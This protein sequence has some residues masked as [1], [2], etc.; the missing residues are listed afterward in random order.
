MSPWMMVAAGA[1]IAPAIFIAWMLY[2][3][4]VDAVI[5][6]GEPAPDFEFKAEGHGASFAELWSCKPLAV[7]WLR[8]YG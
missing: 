7:I 8:H 1:V 2:R 3:P 6:V 5:A 4:K